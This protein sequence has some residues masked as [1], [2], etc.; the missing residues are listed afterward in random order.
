MTEPAWE[1]RPLPV[2]SR[3]SILV[4]R[5]EPATPA[6]LTR[7]RSVL[8]AALLD[9]AC[10]VGAG[11]GPPEG[12]LLT[13]EELVSNALRHGGLPVVVEVVRS[14][15]SWLVDV[16]DAGPGRPPTPA[17][18][19]DAALGGLGLYLVAR[20]SGAYGWTVDG[21]RKHVWARLEH[22]ETPTDP[23]GRLPRPR[24]GADAPTGAREQ[25]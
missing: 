1:Q 24:T 2:R 6:D 17:V 19:R 4:G 25:R 3:D 22:S 14:G 18:G 13:F 10:C 15:H 21:G 12:L 11:A 8:A 20:L 9:G 16:S 5:W 23:P 7:H